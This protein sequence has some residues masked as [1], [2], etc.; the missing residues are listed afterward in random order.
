MISAANVSANPRS[1]RSSAATVR[2][3]VSDSESDTAIREALDNIGV[4]DT[5]FKKG[6]I[7]TAIPALSIGTSPRLLVVD[8]TGIDDPLRR[9]DELAAKCEP[10]VSVITIGDQNDIVLY[11]KLKQVGVTEYFFKPLVVDAFGRACYQGLNGKEENTSAVQTGKLVFVV[12]LRGGVGGTMIAANLAW[13]L[14]EK[15]HR[16]VMLVDM[17]LQNGDAAL[18][19]DTIPTHTLREAIDN[20]ERV[21]KLF[22]ERGAIHAGERLDVL[23]SLE[24]LGQHI[25]VR[26]SSVLSLLKKLTHRYRFTFVDLPAFAAS[27][28]MQMFNESSI[29]LLISDASLVSARNLIRWREFLGPNSIERRALHVMNM[30]GADGGLKEEE[31]IRATGLPPDITIPYDREIAKASAYGVKAMQK[32]VALNKAL[33]PLLRALAG[34][35]EIKPRPLL[36]RIL[37]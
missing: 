5:E 29:C 19:L 1:N 10:D 6:N 33:A 2:V 31:F 37:G 7:E 3:F 16:W 9:I 8:L 23:A 30:Y 21:D 22:L 17:D 24:P 11:R 14:A 25:E 12:G 36:R 32:C 34:E 27:R 15:G 20:P 35:T 18:Q 4:K 13:R 28:L 26:E